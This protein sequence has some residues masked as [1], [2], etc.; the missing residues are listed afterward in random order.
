MLLLLLHCCFTSTVNSYGHVGRSDNL[1]ILILGRLRPPNLFTSTKI[2][3][4]RQLLAI[5]LLESVEGEMAVE[6]VV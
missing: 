3:Y 1:T 4:F 6:K 5:V 2:P